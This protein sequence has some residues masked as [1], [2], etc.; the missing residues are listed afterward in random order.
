MATETLIGRALGGIHTT[1]DF[2]LI[3]GDAVNRELRRS[4]QAPLSGARLLARQ[5]RGI[6][7]FPPSRRN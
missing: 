7:R 5:T 3:L 1:S 4:Y 6:A 2:P